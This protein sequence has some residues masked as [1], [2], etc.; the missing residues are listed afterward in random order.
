[1]QEAR[2][3]YVFGNGLG[4]LA[5]RL[6]DDLAAEPLA[7]ALDADVV[8]VP[9][10]GMGRWLQQFLAQ[11]WGI[12]TLVDA[13]LPAQ[14][15]WRVVRT[16]HTDLPE[17]TSAYDREPLLWRIHALLPVLA[18][19]R[20][21]AVVA[22]YL[23]DDDPRK[24]YELADRLASVFEQYLL[25]RP[26]WLQRWQRGEALGVSHPHE[27]WQAELWRR[28]R[29]DVGEPHRAELIRE[30]AHRV[31]AGRV[32]TS[33]LP[34]RVNV[35]GVSSL[36]PL[37]LQLFA[38]LAACTDLRLY[39][40]NP[41]AEYWGD[42]TIARE[43]PK[44]IAKLQREG[45]AEPEAYLDEGHPLL[46]SWGRLGRD[47]V[48]LLFGQSALQID[49][50]FLGAD[51]EPVNVLSWL[52]AGI[53]R[54]DTALPAPPPDDSLRIVGCASRLRE[55]EVLHDALLAR[56]ERDPTL[57]PRDVV[58]MTPRLGD[59]A[60][61]VD[62][63]FGAAP[64]A[65]RVP[66]TIA[67]RATGG[68][69]AITR[70]FRTLLDLPRSRMP[71]SEVLDLLRVG[72]IA[73]RFGLGGDDHARLV[74]W[75][76]C[77]RVRWG[78][79]GAER[80][81]AGFGD[82]DE[83]SWRAGLDRILLGYATGDVDELV[84]G[85]LPF[86]GIEGQGA[87]AA[88]ALARF[89]ER[90][91]EWRA[92]L[93]ASRDIEA[94]Q[95]LLGNLL[96][97]LF[98]NERVDADEHAALESIRV[99][100]KDLRTHMERAAADGVAIA[101]AVMQAALEARF[102]QPERRQRLLSTGVT[103]CAMVPMRNV[104]FRVVCLLG[105]DDGEFP[106]REPAAS[107]NLMRAF[108]QTGDRN[109]SDDDRYL[110]LEALLAARDHLHLS[111]QAV[112]ARDGTERAPAS[113]VEELAR[114]VEQ[115]CTSA[116]M[117]EHQAGTVGG[118]KAPTAT[119]RPR[120]EFWTRAPATPFAAEAFD[121][122]SH[123]HTYADEWLPAARAAIG[124]RHDAPP[125]LAT[126]E[127]PADIE[128]IALDDLLAW[129]RDP[130]K[131]YCRRVLELSLPESRESEDDE[132]FEH[133]GLDTWQL[134]DAL[135]ARLARR[136]DADDA[137][138]AE[139]LRAE[140][141][142]RA[143]RLGDADARDAIATVRRL[144]DIKRAKFGDA[145]PESREVELPVG[146]VMLRGR[147]DN[148][149]HGVPVR[150]RAGGARGPDWL[151]LAAAAKLVDA[152][153]AWFL[154]IEKGNAVVKSLDA[155]LIPD[156]WLPH[157]VL[158]YASSRARFLPLTRRASWDYSQAAADPEAARRKAKQTLAPRRRD[159]DT[160][161][162]IDDPHVALLWRGRAQEIDAEFE[163]VA[164]AVYGALAPAITAAP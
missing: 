60:P 29:H 103:V 114:F 79:D 36:P 70:A 155:T 132:P 106:R 21:F 26:G 24:A 14:F 149:V 111:Y 89:V 113:V 61:L 112:N 16:L 134:N 122:A 35:L 159:D 76:E 6:A 102:E 126:T 80:D 156:T 20:E 32:D 69:H 129:I 28:L 100:L 59:Y 163:A 1:M 38:A 27:A 97:D 137:W 77:T 19:E 153:E 115:A 18:R 23:A 96:L 110:F 85:A 93:G 39:H 123:H 95:L 148:L 142:L 135:L 152:G 118:A 94:W 164:T 43:R 54:L 147:L 138:L 78:L 150:L 121:P 46:A 87:A 81:R 109:R 48:Q 12:A 52:R 8:V 62:A 30:L 104:P 2:L 53:S 68:T 41:S 144:V 83:F 145:P 143:G 101:H 108:P 58:V 120:D 17:T 151:A 130:P 13:V 124:P 74:E 57:T 157:V 37:Y 98:D 63:V 125:F 160:R 40:V 99:V 47:F 88:G 73:R 3:R 128:V 92:R 71:A 7:D 10:P 105:L 31:Q 72:A 49:D 22:A 131:D 64:E 161:A 136:P 127:S 119:L 51:A 33:M 11:R 91:A 55:V 154:G 117:R 141:L 42:I 75:V 50:E 158:L 34:P 9:H 162:E 56:F 15:A 67:D 107:F 90:L 139:C 86:A 65:R 44:L 116:E 140:G 5:G 66:Y 4:A 45:I 25:Y 84:G 133:S 82:Y 146:S